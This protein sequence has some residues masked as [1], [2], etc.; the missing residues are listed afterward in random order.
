MTDLAILAA[1]RLEEQPRD[2]K[3]A[4]AA[5]I[6]LVKPFEVTMGDLQALANSWNQPQCL[7]P[8]EGVIAITMEMF[9]EAYAKKV[10]LADEWWY[11]DYMESAAIIELFI[12]ANPKTSYYSAEKQDFFVFSAIAQAQKE[13]NTIV[14]CENLS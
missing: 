7:M 8:R 3:E 2:F 14:I 11:V 4:R 13:G 9:M 10:G 12:Q 1:K 5:W 6:P